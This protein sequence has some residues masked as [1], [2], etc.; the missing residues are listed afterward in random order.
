MN[1]QI[2]SLEKQIY[3]LTEDLF[4]AR[5]AAEPESVENYAF[6]TAEG[7]KTLAD[8]FGDRDE[9]ILIH[10]MGKSCSYC[11]M[12]ADLLEGSRR[13]LETRCAIVLISPDDSETQAKLAQA[14]G[15]T[16][17][18]ATD[19]D[20]RFTTEMGY[21]KEDKYW[22]PGCSTFRKQDDGSIVRTGT[23]FFGPGDAFCPPWHFFSLLGI[24][25][26]EWEPH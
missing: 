3:S 5:A 21:L 14:R 6:T 4:K 8:F 7:E 15:W 17:P 19:T 20:R 11:T 23:S 12:W 16:F 18:M 24:Q 22:G 2:K 26:G 9:L 10:N 13:H 25:D 1:D